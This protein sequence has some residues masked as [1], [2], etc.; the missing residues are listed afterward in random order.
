[1]SKYLQIIR[2]DRI[3]RNME[4]DGSRMLSVTKSRKQRT[5]MAG[6]VQIMPEHTCAKKNT[7]MRAPRERRKETPPHRWKTYTGNAMLDIDLK[8]GKEKEKSSF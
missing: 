3:R 1:M 4:P 8:E 6:N 7:A 2:K 5:T